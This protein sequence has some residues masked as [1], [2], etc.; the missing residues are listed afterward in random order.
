MAIDAKGLRRHAGKIV[1]HRRTR[2][3]ALWLVAIVVAVGVFGGLVVPPLLRGKVAA[4]L[5]DKLHRAVSIE[6]IRIN[7][8][9]MSATIRGFL[10]KERQ[11]DAAAI[12]FAEIYVNV[13]L[14][15]IFRG[16]PVIKELRLVKPYVNLI[17]GENFK[18]NFQDL[19]DAGRQVHFGGHRRAGPVGPY[20]DGVDEKAV[21]GVDGLIAGA[22]I[23]MG[24]ELQ[25]FVRARAADDVLGIEPVAC[26]DRLAQ[27]VAAAVGIKVEVR[28]DGA[29]GRDGPGAGAQR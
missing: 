23:G 5:T 28:G 27:V 14:Q 6:Q 16:G 21:G 29:E 10:M 3:I 18:Y 12:S 15:S 22:Q 19:I 26:G 11:S 13:E 7:P 25:Q 24:D 2:K 9:A 8:Y 4:I 1:R 20:G 17:R